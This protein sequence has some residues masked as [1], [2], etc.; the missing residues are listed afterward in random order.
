MERE[1]Q[2][3]QKKQQ[4]DEF[5]K[6]VF[7][8]NSIAS[9]YLLHRADYQNSFF[10]NEVDDFPVM[11]IAEILPRSRRFASGIFPRLIPVTSP[12]RKQV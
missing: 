7:S 11:C 9:G 5:L 3:F 10:I 8:D 4:K 6:F 1:A 12:F 2:L